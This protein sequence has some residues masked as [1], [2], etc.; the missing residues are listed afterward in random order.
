MRPI[1]LL[2]NLS[3]APLAGRE[4]SIQQANAE[5]GQRHGAQALERQHQLDQTRTK[6]GENAESPDNRVDDHPDDGRGNQRRSRRQRSQDNKASQDP[7]DLHA[8][9]PASRQIDLLA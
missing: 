2:D 7:V 9:S 6:A 5:Q 8:P 4:Q 3:K 1:D